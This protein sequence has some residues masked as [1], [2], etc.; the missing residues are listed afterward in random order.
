MGQFLLSTALLAVMIF[1]LV[2]IITSDNWRIRYLPKVA[3]ALLVIFLPLIGSILWF[4][5]GKERQVTVTLGS[6]GDPRRQEAVR[7][8][9]TDE[10]DLAAIEREIEF[11]E[12]QAEIRRLEQQLEAKR[13]NPE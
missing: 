5:L 4:V 8:Q 11:H 13:E 2:D 3:W 1:A 12:K 9:P 6:F 10:D 7:R